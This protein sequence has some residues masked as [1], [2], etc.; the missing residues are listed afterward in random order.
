M[1]LSYPQLA[2]MALPELQ[3]FCHQTLGG[4]LGIEFLEA[5]PEYLKARMPVDHRTVQPFGVL[6]GG[7]SVA[8]AETLGSVGGYLL[9]KD[10]DKLAVGLEIKA[11]H[12]RSV[13]SGWVTGVARP[14]HA[15]RTTQ[16]W[17]IEI[18]D[19]EGKLVCLSRLTLAIINKA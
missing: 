11:N 3:K 19:D 1:P 18:T 8:L 15:G 17:D 10:D 12:I 6:H 14:V 4:N 16:V 13:R 2:A 5:T 9:V 7:A